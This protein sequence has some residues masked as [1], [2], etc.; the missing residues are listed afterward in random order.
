MVC[1]K[2]ERESFSWWGWN[3]N[4]CFPGINGPCSV[5]LTVRLLWCFPLCSCSFGISL[6]I[7]VKLH[8]KNCMP[9]LT[10]EAQGDVDLT[11]GWTQSP[12]TSDRASRVREGG[13]LATFCDLCYIALH[14]IDRGSWASG[15]Q[16][17]VL[18]YSRAQSVWALRQCWISEKMSSSTTVYKV[19]T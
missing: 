12:R 17:L 15:R 8:M 18:S 19:N 16:G 13:V 11:S 10:W 1:G 3:K 4:S 6:N 5:Q 9:W 2:L 14:R 7:L